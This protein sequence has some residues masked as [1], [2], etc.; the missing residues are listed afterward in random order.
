MANQSVALPAPAATGSGAA[1]DMSTFGATKTFVITGSWE[2]AP[3]LTIE[4][5]NSAS[6]GDGGWRPVR[7]FQ[8][9]GRITIDLAVRWARIT[10][11]KYRGGQAPACSVAGTDS[12]TEFA[13]VAGMPAGN[14]TSTPLDVTALG[15][16][17]TID[18]GGPF[19]GTANIE[20]STDGGATYST[21]MSFTSQ[22][23]MQTFVI[24][25]DFIR[26][27]RVNVP[28]SNP[29][30]PI[31]NI[32][33]CTTG[34]GAGD[35]FITSV[36]STHFTVTAGELELNA[37]P[38]FVQALSSDGVV[39]ATSSFQFI[40]GVHAVADLTVRTFNDG[41]GPNLGQANGDG[42]MILESAADVTATAVGDVSVTAG[43]TAALVGTTGLT[44]GTTGGNIVA[45]AQ[46]A[47]GLIATGDVNVT[48]DNL[49]VTGSLGVTGAEVDID[50]G[51]VNGVNIAI[52]GGG[53]FTVGVSGGGN[54]DLAAAG[55][56]DANLQGS[57]VQVN[58]TG[59]AG[60]VRLFGNKLRFYTGGTAVTQPTI[61]GSR[62]GNAALASL[63][64]ALASMGLIVDGTSA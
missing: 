20:L 27:T 28:A 56:G 6:A 24:A 7:T 58:A 17:K 38:L 64:T 35:S 45:N 13:T 47:I 59:L 52:A 54:I 1:V 5:S 12:G 16:F 32:G 11:N 46:G 37:N 25:A 30:L 57:D 8:G 41:T 42:S 53:A 61:T 48:G 2:K 60:E 15:L 39:E 49:E 31:V 4:V 10:V 55:S 33:A 63:L 29:G 21:F 51:G 34:G 40:T 62:G 26:V 43:G 14:G 44:L 36:D 19:G 50:T 22:L 3:T 9:A 23:G 18:V